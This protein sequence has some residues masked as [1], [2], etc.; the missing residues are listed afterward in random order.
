M[1][2]RSVQSR[3]FFETGLVQR[4]PYTFGV[5]QYYLVCFAIFSLFRAWL[6]FERF[7]DIGPLSPAHIAEIF[8]MGC[9]LDGVIIGYSSVLLVVLL[10]AVPRRWGFVI[11]TGALLYT[12][13][14]ILAFVAAEVCGIYFFRYYD[15]RFN[16][17]V[18]DHWKDPQLVETVLEAYPI[19]LVAGILAL[20]AGA[21][22]VLVRKFSPLC[23]GRNSVLHSGWRDRCALVGVLVL[24][25]F[26]MRGSLDRRPL[27]P[28]AAAISKNRLVNEITSSGVFKVVYEG[29][30]R[31]RTRYV[32]VHM[33]IPTLA[34]DD[35]VAHARKYFAGMGRLTEDSANPVATLV[36]TGRPRRNFNVVLIVMESLT[37]KVMGSLGGSPDATP[38]FNRLA[39][40][41]VLL[42]NCYATGE[43]TIQ[44]L[45]ATVCSFPPLPGVGIV[46]RP[47]AQQGFTTLGTLLQ[48]RGYRTVFFYGGQGIFDH[49]IG[50]F[51]ANGYDTFFEEKD[52][53]NP[54]YKTAWGASDEDLYRR[55]DAMARDLSAQGR[56]FFFTILT[57]SLHS[58][59]V[60]P[61]D[62]IA[63][64]PKDVA[65]P[66][67]FEYEEL[68]NYKYAD[69]ALGNFFR[70]ARKS[71]YFKDTV[72]VVIGDHGVHLR[73]RELIPVEEYRVG[74]LFHA[75]GLLEPRRIARPVSQLAVAPTILG[76]L[77]GS[78]RTTFF[79]RDIF[80]RDGEPQY[81][82]MVYDKKRFGV[83]SGNRLTVLGETGTHYAYVRATPDNPWQDAQYSSGHEH[84][85][86]FGTAVLQT[87][88]LLL[89]DR[90]YHAQPAAAFS[91]A[92]TSCGAGQHE[93]EPPGR[94]QEG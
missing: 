74:A 79:G 76:L 87:A 90:T 88:E 31:M 48:H 55:A 4:Y 5:L 81:C 65:I 49:K 86:L 77:G 44:G 37:A 80:D 45:E 46:R 35:A 20:T 16:Y 23:R 67:G 54:I 92:G 78:Y 85:A 68:N 62:T 32:P 71:D 43:R 91:V 15:F 59:W 47:Q 94:K 25:L 89:M 60:Y 8:W 73:G 83:L 11:R 50:F 52:F 72:F 33:V 28:T 19:P 2:R 51:L 58:P 1:N 26:M 56:P 24:T 27:N 75:P 40:E 3:H 42:E 57:S 30:Q 66:P 10:L 34:I 41:S 22:A 70:A 9:R 38:E 93:Q 21:V 69:Y 12:A 17:L 36:D 82:L 64:F 7:S 18:L 53:E 14:C 13:G 39:Q 84:L 6:F 63:T 61:E 29:L